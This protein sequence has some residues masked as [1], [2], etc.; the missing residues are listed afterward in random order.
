MLRQYQLTNFKAFGD[1]DPLPIRPITLIYG[2]NSS[3]KSSIL[4]SLLLLKQTLEEAESTDVRLLP[5]GKLT[6]LGNYRE[7][8]HRHDVNQPFGIKVVFKVGDSPNLGLRITFAYDQQKNIPIFSAVDL[9]QDRED[10]PIVT[11]REETA[12]NN[13]VLTVDTV[14]SE[15]PFWQNWWKNGQPKLLDLFRHQTND[16]IK[17]WQQLKSITAN[18][19]K[20]ISDALAKQIAPLKQELEQIEP[21]QRSQSP[22]AD[23]IDEMEYLIDLDQRLKTYTLA[24]AIEDFLKVTSYS[25]MGYR[26]FL[27]DNPGEWQKEFFSFEEFFPLEIIHL[28]KLH[29]RLGTFEALSNLTIEAANL[30]RVFLGEI[31]YIAPLRDYPERL[32]I[33]SGNTSEQVGK[34]GKGISDLL[35]KRPD[36]LERVNQRLKDFDLKYELKV[37]K[38]TSQD[39]AQLSDIF[40]LRLV[41]QFTDVNVSMLD[42]GFGISQVLPI[43]IQSMASSGKIIM[44]E[45]PEIHIH[46]RLQTELGSL[47]AECI[48]EPFYNDFII[49]THSEHLML[50]LQKLIRKGELDVEDVSVIY[51]DRTADGAKCKLLRLDEEGYFIDEW[52]NGFFEEGYKERFS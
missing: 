29:Q 16:A 13:V 14:H 26:N 36:L 42:V 3:G 31:I 7:F 5:K 2:P 18:Q 32:Y 12:G 17:A 23:C 27:P 35:F 39:T 34:T 21:D 30:L 33:F 38:F 11:Y 15:H 37:E 4:Q 46:P 44:I 20:K 25:F 52:P 48:K 47:L 28:F 41:D 50:R 49:E 6:N 24:Q 10:I 22:L 9:F 8:V 40:A 19:K 1:T 43:I 51:V 45:Q